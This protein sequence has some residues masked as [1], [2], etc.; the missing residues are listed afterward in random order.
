[1]EDESVDD[2]V[3]YLSEDKVRDILKRFIKSL[4][5]N[6]DAVA[7][8]DILCEHCLLTRDEAFKVFVGSKQA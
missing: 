5:A 1:M 7:A 4:I 2:R 6:G 3:D 8:S